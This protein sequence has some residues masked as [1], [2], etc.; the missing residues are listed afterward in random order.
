M[1]EKCNSLSLSY[2]ANIVHSC[3]GLL[4][5]IAHSM[6]TILLIRNKDIFEMHIYGI[7]LIYFLF[8]IKTQMFFVHRVKHYYLILF[9]TV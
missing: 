3:F 5:I 8:S 4:Y 2:V 7:F 1:T 6:Y 9:Y